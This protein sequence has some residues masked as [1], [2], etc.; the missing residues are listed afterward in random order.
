M[1]NFW[2][3]VN[4]II[5]DADILIEVVDAR[6][7]SGTRNVEIEG[8]IDKMGKVMIYCINKCDLVDKKKL[9]KEIRSLKPCVYVSASMRY[10]MSKLRERIVIEGKKKKIDRPRVGVL[11]YPN[12]GKSS[13]INAL[14]GKKSAR[15]S[16]ESG[17]TKGKQYLRAGDILLI[18]SPG[19][20][21]AIKE[22][23]TDRAMV[24][25]IDYAKVKNP[26][27]IVMDV[28]EKVPGKIEK[29]FS[30]KVLEDF[31]ETL[32]KIAL[33]KKLI[34]KGGEAD[35]VRASRMILKLWQEGKIRQF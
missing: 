8:K 18:D 4:R 16:A 19:V 32:E 3:I 12:V 14:K 10:G 5:H 29:Y 6:N 31:E 9:E 25:V 33:K 34:I 17:F 20:F 1:A 13:V 26:D 35:M 22:S 28:M 11:G 2:T 21:P 23:L 24:G 15:T 30:V 7:I 27:L